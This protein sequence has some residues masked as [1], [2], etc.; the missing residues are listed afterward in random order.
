[1]ASEFEMDAKTFL[2]FKTCKFNY[3]L[4]FLQDCL[5]LVNCS[6]YTKKFFPK[7]SKW[8]KNSI[9]QIVCTKIHV[10]LVVEPLDDMF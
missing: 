3:F 4:I 5:N 2:S 1:M 6:S 7:N 10:F 9:W 8:P